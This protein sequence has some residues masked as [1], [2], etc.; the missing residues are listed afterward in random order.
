MY[1]VQ[2]LNPYFNRPMLIN[3]QLVDVQHGSTITLDHCDGSV[4]D[5]Y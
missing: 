5:D 2:A 4:L 3:L 1:A